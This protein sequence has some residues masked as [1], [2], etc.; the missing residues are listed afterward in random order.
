MPTREYSAPGGKRGYPAA[1]WLEAIDGPCAPGPTANRALPALE[2]EV[3]RDSTV[4]QYLAEGVFG[5]LGVSLPVHRDCGVMPEAVPTHV[6]GA[7]EGPVKGGMII[8]RTT[9]TRRPTA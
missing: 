3:G 6:K 7:K 1:H 2:S 8:A 5:A 9:K 4:R